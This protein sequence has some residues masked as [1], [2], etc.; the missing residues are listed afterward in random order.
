MSM[1]YNAFFYKQNSQ[2]YISLVLPFKIINDIS[3]VLI[4]GKDKYG[5][6]R[7]LASSH[8]NQIKKNILSEEILLPTSIILSVN[9]EDIQEDIKEIGN[10]LIELNIHPNNKIFRI[11]DGQHRLKG[12]EEAA[13]EN[14]KIND[15]MLHVIIL[16]TDRK[17]RIVEVDT[18]ININSKAKKIKTDLTLLAKYN[19]E[20]LGEKEID[21]V[22][23]H[24][25]VKVAYQLHEKIKQSVWKNA[26]KFEKSKGIIEVNAFKKSIT[27]LVKTIIDKEDLNVTKDIDIIDDVS[28]Q[29]AKIINREWQIIKNRWE[30]CFEEK[31]ERDLEDEFSLTY[32]NNKYYIQ[33]TTGV[34]ALNMIFNETLQNADT[35]DEA[36]EK[37]KDILQNS[38]IKSDDWLVGKKFSGLTSGSGFKKA[39]K[40]IM[41]EQ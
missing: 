5:Y 27:P 35:V 12:L 11:V 20:I 17:S 3:K 1:N 7:E 19:Y 29:I 40:F 22:F 9:K 10:G 39:K 18:F 2:E 36:F 33:K 26:I 30:A 15:F 4:Y 21:D 28:S 31:I 41:N 6:Q 32:Y 8:Y 16:L 34:N 38:L 14:D 23:E 37:F 25:C 24:I 13:K